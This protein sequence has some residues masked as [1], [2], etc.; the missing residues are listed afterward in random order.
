MATEIFKRIVDIAY[1]TSH[2]DIVFKALGTDEFVKMNREQLKDARKRYD[3][4]VEAG[5]SSMMTLED[6]LDQENAI[7]QNMIQ[8]KQLGEDVNLR[9]PME[10]MLMNMERKDI[11]E[12]FNPPQ[13]E[14]PMQPPGGQPQEMEAPVQEPE[15][16]EFA[17]PGVET[18][19]TEFETNLPE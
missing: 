1:E 17:P 10:N 12:Y 14:H 4:G 9:K 18:D 5:S 7:M 13:P 15:G 16:S 6:R 3:L 11:E 8:L 2:K 19:E